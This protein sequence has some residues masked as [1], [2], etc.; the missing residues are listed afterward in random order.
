MPVSRMTNL[1]PNDTWKMKIFNAPCRERS[2]K[3]KGQAVSSS[4][5]SVQMNFLH[6]Y[7]FFFFFSGMGRER[8]NTPKALVVH[9]VKQSCLAA[10]TSAPKCWASQKHWCSGRNLDLLCHGRNPEKCWVSRLQASSEQVGRPQ[11]DHNFSF[12]LPFHC[13][14]S[15]CTWERE[16]T[17]GFI[18]K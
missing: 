6:F 17:C 5:I 1:R 11:G 9:S 15:F 4:F 13:R 12:L 8:Q 18:V 7:T 3:M 10:T 14:C 16:E 2:I